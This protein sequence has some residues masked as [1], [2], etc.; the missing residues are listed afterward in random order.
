MG[1]VD[2]LPNEK[3]YVDL[4]AFLIEMFSSHFQLVVCERFKFNTRIQLPSKT[5][6]YKSVKK[7]KLTKIL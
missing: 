4:V 6:Q 5:V 2:S 3:T 1:T 7:K